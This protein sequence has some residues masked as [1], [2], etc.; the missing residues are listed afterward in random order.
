MVLDSLTIEKPD[1]G[2]LVVALAGGAAIAVGMFLPW[3]TVTTSS[4][5]LTVSGVSWDGPLALVGVT[6]LA[7]VVVRALTGSGASRSTGVAMVAV[8]AVSLGIAGQFLAA[9]LFDAGDAISTLGVG[10]RLVVFG[11]VLSFGAGVLVLTRLGTL[12]DDSSNTWKAVAIGV[13]IAAAVAIGWDFLANQVGGSEF[14]QIS[15]TLD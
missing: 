8:G 14:S 9:V 6:L 5:G 7:A 15:M 3:L 11:A 13:G 1:S 10:M 4:G 2:P 12:S